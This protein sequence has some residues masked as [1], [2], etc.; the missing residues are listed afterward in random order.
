[1]N[2]SRVALLAFLAAIAVLSA[3]PVL[4]TAYSD[5]AESRRK[6]ASRERILASLLSTASQPGTV[7]QDLQGAALVIDSLDEALQRGDTATRRAAA[8]MLAAL[9]V[10]DALASLALALRDKDPYVRRRAAAAL[11]KGG[12][13]EA[14]QHVIA[15]LREFAVEG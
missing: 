1:M 11:T 13:K 14:I 10:D 6:R 12:D 2:D 3:I 4:V 7:P 8:D 15:A 9:H 5:W